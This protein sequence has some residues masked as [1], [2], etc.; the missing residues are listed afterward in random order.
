MYPSLSA[1]LS[2]NVW[3]TAHRMLGGGNAPE[4]LLIAEHLAYSTAIKKNQGI[5]QMLVECTIPC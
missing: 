4:H 2:I 5:A 3:T 1:S